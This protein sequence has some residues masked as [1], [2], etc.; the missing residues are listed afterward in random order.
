[1]KGRIFEVKSG[2][3]KQRLMEFCRQ[4]II[5]IFVCVHVSYLL[6]WT[7]RKICLH[8]IWKLWSKSPVGDWISTDFKEKFL[9]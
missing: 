1:M 3:T 9:Q 2:C 4:I 5:N 6:T 8:L 7:K